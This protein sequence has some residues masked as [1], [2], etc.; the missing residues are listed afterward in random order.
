MWSF[1]GSQHHRQW[2]WRAL[3]EQSAEMVGGYVG[4]RDRGGAKGRWASLPAVYRQ[5][6]GAYTDFWSSYEELLP[7]R[8]HRAVGKET[9]GTS[10]IERF[11][12]TMR[13]RLSRLVRTTLSFSK[14]LVNQIGAIWLFV[15]HYNASLGQ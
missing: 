11:N 13:Q 8:R 4:A 6:A 1:V 3:D 9:G 2:I 7:A 15:H 12:K 14:K 5:C 10:K